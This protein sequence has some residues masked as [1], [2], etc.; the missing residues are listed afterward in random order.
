MTEQTEGPRSWVAVTTKLESVMGPGRKAGSWTQYCCPVHEADGRRHRPSLG[1]KYLADAERTKIECY[2]GCPDT[3]ILEVLGLQVRD[4]YDAPRSS[5]RGR[6]AQAPQPTRAPSRAEQAIEAAGLPP[7]SH[8]PDLGAQRSSWRTTASYSYVR[9]D[10]TVAGAVRRREARFDRGTDKEFVQRSWDPTTGSWAKTGFDKIP[11]QLP[12]VLDAI[13]D[14]D[15]VIYVCE[16][17]KDVLAAESA[18]LVATTNAGGALSWTAE[19]AQWLKGAPT[20]IIVVDQDAAGYRRA[21]KVMS[22]LVG[23]VPRVRVVGAATGKDLHDHLQCGHEIADL[24]PVPGLDPFTPISEPTPPAAGSNVTPGGTPMPEYLLMPSGDA[25]AQHSDDLDNM[26]MQWRMFMQALMQKVFEAVSEAIEQKIRYDEMKAQLAEEERRKADAEQAA[27]RATAEARLRK[28]REK[29]LHNASRTEIVEAV[30]DAAAWAG[31]SD[32]AKQ[33]LEDLAAHV[34][35]RYGLRIDASTGTVTP[36]AQAEEAPELVV[37]LRQAEI[38]RADQARLR[39]AQDR[40]VQMIAAQAEL[41]DEVKEELYGEIAKWVDHPTPKQLDLLSKKLKASGLGEETTTAMRLVAVYLG[42]PGRVVPLGQL[43]EYES[44]V[45]TRELRRLPEAL[46]SHGEEAKARVDELLVR[47]QD[48]LRVGGPT[49]SLRERLSETVA[50]MDSEDQQ[51]ARERGIAIRSDPTAKFTKLWPDHVDRDELTSA[52][53]VYATVAP[54]ADLAAGQAAAEGKTADPDAAALAKRAAVHRKTIEK[55][56]DKGKG[57]HDL[58][59]D[60]LRLM[61]ADVE[62]GKSVMPELMWLDERTAASV[63]RERSERIAQQTARTTERQAEQI[64]ESGA[65]PVGAARRSGV[66]LKRVIDAHTQLAAGRAGLPDVEQSGRLE[67]LDA[68][69]QTL[70]VPEGV[71]HR[72]HHH[73]DQGAGDA[74]VVGKQARRI[75]EVWAE[76]RDAVVE[77]NSAKPQA[78]PGYDTE[79]RRAQM[80]RDLQSAGLSPAKVAQRMAADAGAAHPASAATQRSAAGKKRT[81]R[82]GAGVQRTHHRGK[83]Q[84]PSLGR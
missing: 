25:P 48:A 71:R 66:E 15:R 3:E 76:R 49:A 7:K 65:T 81:T 6:S 67:Q 57:L 13:A 73:L 29:G 38:G 51:L 27:A 47:Y 2:A 78:T 75:A 4:L 24:V 33:S 84:G 1:A 31:D 10:G 61:L 23:V 17:E 53:R 8:K 26:G 21:E 45:A 82:H 60:Q 30:R 63:D 83:G 59:R 80:A 40:M 68:K 5:G 43:G 12:Q 44:A 41:A 19:H 50:V 56:L 14:G 20:V 37:A 46:V 55:A 54:K 11:Y 52:V 62:A 16:G 36:S 35:K 42:Q 79:A 18:G 9:A 74:S 58:E 28:L 39:I 64:L 70:R 22:S 69:L 32:F 72:L 77:A 34:E